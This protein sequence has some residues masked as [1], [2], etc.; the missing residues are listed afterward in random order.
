VILYYFLKCIY[1]FDK[2]PW[3]DK[4]IVICVS[5]NNTNFDAKIK[6][7]DGAHRKNVI[8]YYF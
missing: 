7:S 2:Y 5:R 4:Q 8:L 6:K 1:F 3:R